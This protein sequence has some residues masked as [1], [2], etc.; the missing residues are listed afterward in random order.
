MFP[1]DMIQCWVAL[2]KLLLCCNDPTIGWKYYGG[3]SAQYLISQHF[4]RLTSGN[5]IFVNYWLPRHHIFLTQV[6]RADGSTEE[7]WERKLVMFNFIIFIVRRR[8]ILESVSVLVCRS[9]STQISK[10]AIFV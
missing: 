4:F 6:I 7:F 9:V 3:S 5:T 10:Q 8:T 1:H 2:Y